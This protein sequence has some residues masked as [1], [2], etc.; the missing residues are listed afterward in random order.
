MKKVVVTGFGGMSPIGCNKQD[1]LNNAVNGISGIGKIRA[2]DTSGGY[3]HVAGEATEFNPA[4]YFHSRQIKNS[5]RCILM[6]RA[7]AKQ[8]FEDSGLGKE[9]IDP[10]RFGVV[11][12][13]AIGGI[14]NIEQ[15]SVQIHT[16]GTKALNPFFIPSVLVDMP[17]GHIAVD[18]GAKGS[19]LCVTSACA[20]GCDAIGTAYKMIRN[21]EADV[22]AAGGAE[23]AITPLTIAGFSAMRVL[24]EGEDLSVASVPFDKRRSGFVIGEGS[25]CL[26]LESEEHALVRNARIYGSVCGYGSTCDAGHI[27]APSS[28]GLCRAI[29]IAL[30]DSGISAEKIGYINA[31]GTSTGA[32][33][34]AESE[35]FF[36]MFGNN[37]PPVSSLKSLTGHMLGAAGAFET[38]V[39][40]LA[41]YEG[42]LPVQSWSE[43]DEKCGITPI[44]T[45]QDTKASIALSTSLGFGGHNAA[46]LIKKYEK[47]Q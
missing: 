37:I 24:Y 23:A 7:A 3:V 33:D 44:H 20:S 6:A 28:D 39:T 12:S 16:D 22:V 40:L 47:D 21:G 4:D 26:I 36:K 32:N 2:F 15:N 8:A 13:S 29:R 9:A 30:S 1:I 25:C 19:C 34:I 42:K 14:Q 35:S 46:L 11:F 38:G 10:E 5:S 41:L 31:H 18:L 45:P 43:L 17:A 27:V